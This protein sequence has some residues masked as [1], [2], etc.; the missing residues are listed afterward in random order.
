MMKTGVIIFGPLGH[1]PCQ[2]VDGSQKVKPRNAGCIQQLHKKHT[3]CMQ[4]DSLDS[5]T[6]SLG[7]EVSYLS[8]REQASPD[9]RNVRTKDTQLCAYHRKELDTGCFSFPLEGLELTP[10]SIFVS[11]PTMSRYFSTDNFNNPSML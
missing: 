6:H 11:L 5:V 1:I 2:C 4:L 7:R 9:R 10:F 3:R 8:R